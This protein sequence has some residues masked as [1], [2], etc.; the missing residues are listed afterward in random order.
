MGGFGTACSKI[1]QDFK[2]VFRIPRF[3]SVILFFK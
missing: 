2:I 3:F 1:F